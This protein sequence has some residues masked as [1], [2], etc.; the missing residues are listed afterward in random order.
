MPTGAQGSPATDS[1]C[2]SGSRENGHSCLVL[3]LSWV[4]SGVCKDPVSGVVKSR[5]F[6]RKCHSRSWCLGTLS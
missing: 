1:Y 5:D 2:L 3:I 6:I 4:L